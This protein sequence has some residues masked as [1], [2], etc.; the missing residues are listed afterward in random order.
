[1]KCSGMCS[2]RHM[3]DDLDNTKDKSASLMARTKILYVSPNSLLGGGEINQ[4]LLA[5]HVDKR[6][7]DVEVVVCSEGPYA[8]ELR[9]LDIPVTVLPARPVR[10]R[11]RKAPSPASALRLLRHIRR[12]KPDLVHSSSLPED[13]HSAIAAWMAKVPVVHD[14]QTIVHRTMPLDRWRAA[15]SARVICIS[16]AI[17]NALARAKISIHNTEIIYSGVDMQSTRSADGPRIR[18]ELGL[19]GHEVVGIA[20][21]LSPEKGQAHFLRAAASLKGRFPNAR[22]LIA[23][24]ALY[25]PQGYETYLHQ[26]SFGLGLTDQVIFTGFRKD[27]LDVIDAMDVLVCAADEEALG[28]VVLEAM[29]LAKPV[30]ATKAGGPCETVE[31]G[32][33]GVLVPP[34]HAASLAGAIAGLLSDAAAARRMG[35][36][37]R[38]RALRLYT[39]EQN[40]AKVQE[41]Y[42]AILAERTAGGSK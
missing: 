13:Y 16:N 33:T 4:M 14:A 30:I 17:R 42:H 37:G 23:G 41:L 5:G 26:L 36:L 22:F 31:D 6:T 2:A 38:E 21:R 12:V 34:K 40:V 28:R 10:F 3:P 1:M 39:L 29:A 8:D 35:T 24:G 20:S 19:T 27:V 9:R 7:F 15:K 32:V 18:R 11:S 25:A